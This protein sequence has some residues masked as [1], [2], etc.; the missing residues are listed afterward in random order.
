MVVSEQELVMQIAFISMLVAIIQVDITANADNLQA[1]ENVASLLKAILEF[2]GET[3]SVRS[4]SMLWKC[5]TQALLETESQYFPDLPTET[6]RHLAIPNHPLPLTYLNMSDWNLHVHRIQPGFVSLM[7]IKKW[8]EANYS[9]EVH[10]DIIHYLDDS[11]LLLK[12]VA[13]I[14]GH[15]LRFQDTFL[16]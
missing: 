14:C 1:V 8:L 11:V 2:V 3:L 15:E 13:D 9:T 6:P 4:L 10:A 5:S 16:A 12:S 7:A